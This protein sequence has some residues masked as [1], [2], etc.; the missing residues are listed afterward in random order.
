MSSHT[1]VVLDSNYDHTEI[2][3]GFIESEGYQN[4]ICETIAQADEQ[5][6]KHKNSIIMLNYQVILESKRAEVIEFFKKLINRNRLIMYNVPDNAD[7]RLAFY[8]LGAQRV[9]DTSFSLEEVFYSLKWLLR[10]LSELESDQQL[11]SKGKLEDTSLVNL[12]NSLG[13]ENRTGVL[14]IVSRNNSGKIYFQ[15]GDID[16]AQVG[17][18]SG[19]KALVHLLFW[20]EGNFSFTPTLNEKQRKKISLSN[21]GA[22]LYAE[23]CHTK[24]IENIAQLGTLQTILRVVNK[25]DILALEKDIRSGFIDYLNG[26]KTLDDILENPYYVSAETIEI[27]LRLKKRGFLIITE[28]QKEEIDFP[29]DSFHSI[30][31]GFGEVVLNKDEI[32]LLKK[33]L[34]IKDDKLGK[35]LIIAAKS[36]G[37]T[38]FIRQ[39]T[40]S[41]NV[42]RTEQN[43]D[44]AQVSFGS[45]LQLL[46]FGMTM[47]Q[48]VMET[49]EK[50]SAGLLG[51]IF[52]IDAADIKKHE[53]QNYI[54]NHLLSRYPVA[55]VIAV[56]GLAPDD[57]FD[58][59]KSRF[60]S[61]VETN[62]VKSNPSDIKSIREV[63]LAIKQ[64][65][66][67]VKKKEA[68]K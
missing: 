10:N 47:E 2:L 4:I 27:L 44:V 55:H 6:A 29:A 21:V 14:K 15:N 20:H 13:R 39:I 67:P 12:I 65:R 51:Y 48:M 53:Y 5:V 59:I 58:D 52:M 9:F 1:I 43:I 60:Q 66:K 42:S 30:D 8:E 19:L 22:I 31:T 35:V 11:Y 56:S 23:K 18:H 64:I 28:P 40:K 36:A 46:L 57:D 33:N 16:D 3:S 7:Q 24:F 45:E 34:R 63:L 25:G 41:S 50:L 49:T 17:P 61:P 37:K 54:I 32:G 38:E 26:P 62:W 68:K